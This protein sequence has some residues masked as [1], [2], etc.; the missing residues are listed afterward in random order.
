VLLVAAGLLGRTVVNLRSIELGFEPD[1]LLTFAVDPHLHGF[2]SKTLDQLAR[3]LELRL[4]E[5]GRFGGAG[6]VSPTPLS[7]SYITK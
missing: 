6:F 2:E 7:S 1:R 4:R 3:R 5:E